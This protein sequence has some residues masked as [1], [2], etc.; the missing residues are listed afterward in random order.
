MINPMKPQ[1]ITLFEYQ[2]ISYLSLGIKADD[3]FLLAL[4]NV[5]TA[6]GGRIFSLER[7]QFRA[8]NYVGV[9]QV[10]D[11]IIE[12][13]PKIDFEMVD[14]PVSYQQSESDRKR[15]AA[16]NFFYL[17][18]HLNT[19]S[20]S[21]QGV[22]T[23]YRANSTWLE[24]LTQ[25]FIELLLTEL[26]RG[27]NQDYVRKDDY[28]PYIRGRWNITRQFSTKPL[29]TEGLDVSF[30]D[31]LPDTPLNRVFKLTVHRLKR[32]T[33]DPTN[34]RGLLDIDNWLHEVTLIP[35]ISNEDLDCFEFSRLNERFK[36]AFRM[37]EMFLKGLSVQLFAGRQQAYSIMFN[38]DK[39]FED[40]VTKFMTDRSSN[41]LPSNLKCCEV[42][43][44][45][46]KPVKNLI[47]RLDL[48]SHDIFDLKPDIMFK[49]D[50]LTR[51]II[52]AKNKVLIENQVNL[53]VAE[54]DIYQMLAYAHRFD[55]S[56]FLLLYPSTRNQGVPIRACFKTVSK[57]IIIHIATINLH[58]SLHKITPLKKEIKEILNGISFT[59]ELWR[60]NG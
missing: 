53:G 21:P 13:L 56:N 4:D 45:G 50:G 8:T 32:I 11:W 59:D 25:L 12:V 7:D 17:I 58:Q 39:L 14:E 28:L 46:G 18:N 37:A 10:G 43:I 9:V 27:F 23:L 55:C 3:L 44:Q 1:I 42:E 48:G 35:D 36:P 49:K 41:A 26:G 51:L 22:V 31:Y 57:D 30:D 16:K 19:L 29:L 24:N 54:S 6:D 47:Q 2:S 15:S 34:L 40:L 20:L 38:M 52:D 33:K 5:R 60:K